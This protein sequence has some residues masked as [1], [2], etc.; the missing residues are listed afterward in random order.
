[1]KDAVVSEACHQQLLD[2]LSNKTIQV[3]CDPS[4]G[5]ALITPR[6]L[7]IVDQWLQIP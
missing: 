2:A 7:R 5:H 3:H 4:S 6:V 1:M